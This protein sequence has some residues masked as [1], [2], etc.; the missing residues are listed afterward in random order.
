MRSRS[1]N[2]LSLPTRAF[3]CAGIATMLLGGVTGCG[4]QKKATAASLAPEVPE[5]RTVRPKR[6]AFARVVE[7]P[8][9]IEAFEQ[10][11]IYA[12]ISG[13]VKEVQVEIGSRVKQGDLLA[14]LHVPEM[15]EELKH[16]QGLVTQAQLEIRQAETFVAVANSKI[17]TAESLTQEVQAAR[18][19]AEANHQYWKSQSERFTQLVKNSV[20]DKQSEEETLSRFRESESTL[21][22]A[23]V[24]IRTAELTRTE[25]MAQRDKAEADLAAAR[26]RLLLAEIEERRMQSLLAYAHIRA[27]YDGVVTDRKVHTGHFL[28]PGLT[29]KGEPLFVVVRTDKVRVF[30]EVPEADAILVS[31]GSRGQIRVQALN[32]RE[33]VGTVAGTS[34]SLEPGQRTLRTEIDFLN[35]DELLRPGMYVHA[36]IQTEQSNCRTLPSAALLVRDGVS[37]CYQVREGK[38]QRLPLRVGS[39]DRDMVEI[40]KKQVRTE[41][42]GEKP[43]WVDLTGEEEVIAERPGEL[44]EGQTVRVGSGS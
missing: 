42:P 4:G 37:F 28:Q 17:Q 25:A 21:D 26:N 3:V 35:P 24:R 22:E 36:Q 7:Q 31:T 43:R 2:S 10:T 32:D 30:M 39:R 18:K 33:F 41:K 12:K 5:V 8:G 9:R 27:P 29:G 19:R 44:S 14:V 11:P 20:L 15:T 6:Q 34:W 38:L 1:D 16:K 40:L 13:F 23:G